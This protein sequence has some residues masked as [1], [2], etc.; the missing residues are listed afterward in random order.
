MKTR[1]RLWLVGG[2]PP[3]RR[4]PQPEARDP[5]ATLN[6]TSGTWVDHIS[7]LL[8]FSWHLYLRVFQHKSMVTALWTG[9]RPGPLTLWLLA[10]HHRSHRSSIV[11]ESRPLY[12]SGNCTCP[13]LYVRSAI[14]F[15]WMKTVVIV[16]GDL[17]RY[18]MNITELIWFAFN[19]SEGKSWGNTFDQTQTQWNKFTSCLNIWIIN[20]DFQEEGNKVYQEQRVSFSE[21]SFGKDFGPILDNGVWKNLERRWNPPTM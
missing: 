13:L 11:R 2:T 1:H 4:H 20:L 6:A 8:S 15:P 14:L 21:E 10:H 17:A 5:V 9:Y 16:W 12:T 18:N 7:L 19:Y 3:G